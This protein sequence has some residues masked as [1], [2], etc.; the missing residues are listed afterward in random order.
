M[1]DEYE[2]PAATL[3]GGG[4]KSRAVPGRDD[5]LFAFSIA[6]KLRHTSSLVLFFA[7]FLT[8][9]LAS[10]RGLYAL[11]LAGLQVKGVTLDLLDNVLCLDLTLEA[12][13]GV[14]Y[15][16]ALLNF[17]FCQLKQHPQTDRKFTPAIERRVLI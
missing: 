4:R 8:S 12:A 3:H 7:N 11:F 1:N 14:F 17:Y 13:Q 5:P 9:A 16:F 15:R 6:P 10:Q 2:I